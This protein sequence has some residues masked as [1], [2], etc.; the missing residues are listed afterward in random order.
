MALNGAYSQE[1]LAEADVAKGS[2]FG[3]TLFLVYIND[4]P[5]WCYV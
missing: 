5:D 4:L 1:N 3:L 2:M